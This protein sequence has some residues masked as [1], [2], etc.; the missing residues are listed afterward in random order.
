MRYDRNGVLHALLAVLGSS[1]EPT[2]TRASR[3]ALEEMGFSISESSVSRRLRELD[4]KGWTVPVGTKGRVLSAD[5]RSR[6]AQFE[7]VAPLTAAPPQ[8]TVD[9]KDFHD[10]ID[11]LYARKAVESAAA[12]DAAANATVA[13][14]EE[15]Q[16]VVDH[17]RTSLGTAA[18]IEQPGLDLHRRIASIAPNSMLRMLT[19]L[20]L[21]PHLDNVEATLDIALGRDDHQAG[22]VDEH[23][24][25]ADAIAARDSVRAEKVVNEHFDHMILAAEQFLEEENVSVVQRLMD[26]MDSMSAHQG[27]AATGVRTA[28]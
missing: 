22:V 11:L 24:E 19:G 3:N 21:G 13:D 25:I 16:K 15:L 6:L 23:Q 27:A 17:H 4:D 10:V 20:V 5:G 9:I 26:W 8:S 1:S 2:G 14:I 18:M 7:Q 28:R 12:A